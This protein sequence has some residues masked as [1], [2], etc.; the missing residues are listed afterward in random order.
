MPVTR[1]RIL[2]LSAEVLFALAIVAAIILYAEVG[3]FP[4]MPSVRWWGLAV[5][6]GLLFWILASQYRPYWQ[7]RSLW[8]MLAGLLVL[9]L[10]AWTVVLVKASKWGLVWFVPPAVIEGA[11]FVL[12]LD[13][14]GFHPS[15]GLPQNG[16]NG[17]N[18]VL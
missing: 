1:K 15:T 3:H 14:L 10:C 6:T 8:V 17:P 18:E 13:K 4:W 7:R 12:V 5:I 9:H 11:A 2:T 16:G